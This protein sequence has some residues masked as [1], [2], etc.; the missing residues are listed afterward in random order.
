MVA[1]GEAAEKGTKQREE[2]A[3]RRGTK[4]REEALQCGAMKTEKRWEKMCKGKLR[5]YVGSKG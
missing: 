2:A 1:Q 3:Q 5:K 4:K